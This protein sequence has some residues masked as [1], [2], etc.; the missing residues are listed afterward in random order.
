MHSHTASL[1]TISSIVTILFITCLSWNACGATSQKLQHHQQQQQQQ[2]QALLPLASPAAPTTTS[3]ATSNQNDELLRQLLTLASSNQQQQPAADL[4]QE[5]NELKFNNADGL[6]SKSMAALE[7]RLAAESAKQRKL[8]IKRRL[9]K[10]V[11]EIVDESVAADEA[12]KEI[13]S[14][15]SHRKALAQNQQ[16]QELQQ[17]QQQLEKDDGLML[18]MKR[19]PLND[20]NELGND[21]FGQQQQQQTQSQSQPPRRPTSEHA[22][23]ILDDSF[24][25]RRDSIFS[26]NNHLG[27]KG[28]PKFG[29]EEQ[30]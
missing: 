27:L 25:I 5:T 2:P 18:V 30:F 26:S 16:V 15:A 22:R 24:G 19:K 9:H 13:T 6:K 8:A 29:S 23:N 3:T 14:A 12:L 20:I 7:A 21:L 1:S 10:L 17:Q 11:D 4:A 28:V